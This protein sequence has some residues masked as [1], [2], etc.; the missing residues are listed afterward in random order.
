M[1]WCMASSSG[2]L[3]RNSAWCSCIGWD[4]LWLFRSS[5][6][7]S[8]W[9][10]P[11]SAPVLCCPEVWMFASV[12]GS[13]PV[14]QS[15][16]C[17]SHLAGAASVWLAPGA[18]CPRGTFSLVLSRFASSF[19]WL[20]LSILAW[21]LTWPGGCTGFFSTTCFATAVLACVLTLTTVCLCLC[22]ARRDPPGAPFR[23]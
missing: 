12:G 9:V 3:C 15:S 11:A 17:C 14:L 18:G 13:I 19:S 22:G 10:G 20:L 7:S 16:T 2:I 4:V 5:D 23:S 6:S 8:L 1:F 21:A